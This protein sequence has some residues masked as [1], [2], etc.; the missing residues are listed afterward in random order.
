MPDEG[1]AFIALRSLVRV[2]RHGPIQSEEFHVDDDPERDP[3][4]AGPAQ[5]RPAVDQAELERSIG[6][7]LHETPCIDAGA[8]SYTRPC[9]STAVRTREP[10]QSL[11]SPSRI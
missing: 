11:R 2:S 7:G 10:G 3:C 9:T 6:R 4:I 5:R 8:R 1:R